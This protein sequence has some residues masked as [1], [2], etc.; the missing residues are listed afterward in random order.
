MLFSLSNL[1][2]HFDPDGTQQATRWY[3]NQLSGKARDGRD[4][5]ASYDDKPDVFETVKET[6]MP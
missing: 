1:A 6:A 5:A 2:F 4:A 3:H